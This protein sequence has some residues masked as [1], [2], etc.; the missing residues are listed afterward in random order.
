MGWSWKILPNR[1]ARRPLK[2]KSPTADWERMVEIIAAMTEQSER[3]S[4]P[5][6]IEPSQT[7]DKQ[8]PARHPVTT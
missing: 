2:K 6:P 1:I 7:S 8:R 5:Q 3:P 4:R